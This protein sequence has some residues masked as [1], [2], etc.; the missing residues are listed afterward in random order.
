MRASWAQALGLDEEEGGS[1]GAGDVSL[2]AAGSQLSQQQQLSAQR[3]CVDVYVQTAPQSHGGVSRG[4][5][6]E[7]AL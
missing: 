5:S 3:Q 7:L 4:H 2:K 1:A 6:G